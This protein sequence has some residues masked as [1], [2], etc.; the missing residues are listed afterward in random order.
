MGGAACLDT[1][2]MVTEVSPIDPSLLV[3]SR[4]SSLFTKTGGSGDKPAKLPVV[5]LKL[6]L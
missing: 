2:D 5:M 3:H 1:A 6:S 4:F